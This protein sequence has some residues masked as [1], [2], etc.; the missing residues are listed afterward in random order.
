MSFLAFDP[1]MRYDGPTI[2]INEPTYNLAN[3]SSDAWKKMKDLL[4]KQKKKGRGVGKKFIAKD[5]STH[6]KSGSKT[7]TGKMSDSSDTETEVDTHSLVQ[8]SQDKPSNNFKPLV[9]PQNG[10]MTS[11]QT[12]LVR[13]LAFSLR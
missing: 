6:T 5:E 1:A 9:L 11:K 4:K 2:Q 10:L 7:K 8:E 3:E 12:S 13:R